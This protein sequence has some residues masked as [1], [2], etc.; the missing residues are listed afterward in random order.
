[1][2]SIKLDGTYHVVVLSKTFIRYSLIFDILKVISWKCIHELSCDF[3]SKSIVRYNGNDYDIPYLKNRC[4]SDEF[5]Q[6]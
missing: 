5:E 3:Y 4:E 6:T 2:Y 1:M